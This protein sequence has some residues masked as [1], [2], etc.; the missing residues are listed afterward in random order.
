VIDLHS[1]I[2]PGVDDGAQTIEDSLEIAREALA[3]G[4]GVLAGTPH[5]RDDYPT[6]AAQM[7][8][9]LE[10]LRGA[11]RK[12]RI[13]LD[14][15]PGGEIALDRLRRVTMEERRRFG[16][17]GN[18]AYLLLEFPYSVWPMPLHAQVV[19]LR[20]S[21]MRPVLAHPERNV[22]VQH[23]PERLRPL[24]EAGA[25]VQVTAA[26]LDGR[27][28]PADRETALKLIDRGLAHMIVSDAHGHP[29]RAPGV[30]AALEVLGDESVGRWLSYDVPAAIVAG[31][32]LPPR[33]VRRRA[34]RVRRR[35]AVGL[36]GRA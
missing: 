14:V 10:E 21:G 4:V 17:A 15:R 7:E 8:R 24:V 3:D 28:T 30:S 33:P 16:L 19:E 31:E 12:A 29:I 1:H 23:H 13:A 27:G 36:F 20:R 11:L 34:G 9:R 6:S 32:P 26:S 25:L 35:I 2:L 22:D 18:P 5:V